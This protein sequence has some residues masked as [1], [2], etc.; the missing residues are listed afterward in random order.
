MT[1]RWIVTSEHGAGRSTKD[2]VRMYEEEKEV[3]QVVADIVADTAYDGKKLER[4]YKVD[5]IAGTMIRYEPTLE[6]LK[7]VLKEVKSEGP[8]SLI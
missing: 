5:L 1:K 4:I 8:K 2:N 6:K 7:L 3:L